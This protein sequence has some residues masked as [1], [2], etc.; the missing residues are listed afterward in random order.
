MKK[1]EKQKTEGM[2]EQKTG[3]LKDQ[4]KTVSQKTRIQKANSSE[5][6]KTS[7]PGSQNTTIPED[8]RPE[9]QESK[10]LEAKKGLELRKSRTR[11]HQIIKK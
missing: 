6:Q 8:R 1:K 4:N 11:E 9:D 10:N 7:R 2:N 5:N 3:S